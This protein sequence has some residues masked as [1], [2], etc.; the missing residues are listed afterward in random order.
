[1]VGRNKSGGVKSRRTA[2]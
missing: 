1:L 2:G